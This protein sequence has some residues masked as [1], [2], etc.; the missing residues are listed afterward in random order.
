MRRAIIAVCMAIAV[1][2]FV[3]GNTSSASG[4]PSR[5]E[6]LHAQEVLISLGYGLGTADGTM[7]PRTRSALKSFQIQFGLKP[8][9]RL[10]RT[11][12]HTLDI[13]APP[14]QPA[15]PVPAPAS[16]A[17]TSGATDAD[18]TSSQDS[19]AGMIFVLA[20]ICFFMWLAARTRKPRAS[21]RMPAQPAPSQTTRVYSSNPVPSRSIRPT[22]S[23]LTME[24]PA[25]GTGFSLGHAE[26]S[27][28]CWVSA[29]QKAVV[30]GH[31]IQSGMIYVGTELARQNGYGADNCLINPT[32]DVS[33]TTA[34]DS[35][36]NVPYWPSYALLDRAS[37]LSFLKWLEGG[38]KDPSIYIGYVFLYFYGLERR[39][40]LDNPGEEAPK[41]VDEI[42]RLLSIY[43]D[44]HSFERYASA[45]LSAAAVKLDLS[46]EW[47]APSLRKVTWQLPLDL[48]VC[49][50]RSVA[51]GT[52]L[53][54]NQMLAWYNAHPDKRL[55][56]LAGRCPDEFLTLFTARF[57][58]KY[59]NG[60]K[61]DPPK[62]RLSANYRAASGS[63]SVEIRG[64]VAALPDVTGLSAPLNLLDPLVDACA[65]D[66]ATYARLIGKDRSPR[67]MIAA[68][69]SLPTQ[70]LDTASAKPIADLKIWL[71]Q[72]VTGPATAVRLRDLF[73]RVGVDL[74][75]DARATKTDLVLVAD[76]LA[77]CGFGIEPDPRMAYP[78]PA[79]ENEVVVF[80]ADGGA[81]PDQI[82]PEFLSSL[83]HI[84]IGMLVAMADG[85]IAPTELQT[86]A[87]AITHNTDLTPMEQKRLVAR[88][89]LLAKNP[90]T[91]RI[92]TRFKDRPLSDREA[93]ARLAIAVAAADGAMAVEELRLLEKIYKALELPA[94][95][96]YSDVQDFA[97]HDDELA[98]VAP[99]DIT[100]SIPIPQR[101]AP[102]VRGTAMSLDAKRLART[103]ADTAVVSSILG[104]I[105]RDDEPSIP[106]DPIHA[107]R[108]PASTDPSKLVTIGHVP[109]E[110]L[111]EKYV[112]LMAAI[113]ARE[114]ISRG[115]FEVLAGDHNLLCDGAIEAIN[116]WSYGRFDQ[117]VLDDGPQ[118]AINR[119][120]LNLAEGVAT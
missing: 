48:L 66:L 79:I 80:R 109:F 9:G 83:T 47:P 107:L 77:R 46:V 62:R 56:P 68:A 60:I 72:R 106:N 61:V 112:P 28:R 118:I 110:G 59:P 102:P 8:T 7:G 90:P 76:A 78:S 88:L 96:L 65:A 117:P 82:R 4:A 115:D 91:A 12:L 105:F 51:Q 104:E 18:N 34:N 40:M 74:A 29:D 98:T 53:N 84:D 25:A 44:N 24:L 81:R 54:A 35:G 11:T 85:V 26:Q 49:I 5:A 10:D 21:G 23:P 64:A 14:F 22:S 94:A 103:R 1:C 43:H 99:A 101:P 71:E 41:I 55:P 45:L 57:A 33:T 70:L 16:D 52:A 111:D 17:S 50:G 63:F 108:A 39:L 37:R 67:N 73:E 15:A 19:G 2:I 69:A 119:N 36:A 97:T 3:G 87:D 93:V 89:A 116:D 92:L 30:S 58:A 13:Q 38:K 114:S 31:A 75:P 100:K 32:L 95:R 42:K 113:A 86:L 27:R 6:L 120:V 20:A